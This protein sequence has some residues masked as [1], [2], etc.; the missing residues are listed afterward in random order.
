LL[1]LTVLIQQS[2]GAYNN[3]QGHKRKQVLVSR[4]T[5]A[6]PGATG[7]TSRTSAAPGKSGAP[8]ISGTSGSPKTISPTATIVPTTLTTKS[9]KFLYGSCNSRNYEDDEYQYSNKGNSQDSGDQYLDLFVRDT[10]PH[11]TDIDYNRNDND[12]RPRP[13]RT[14]RQAY[15]KVRFPVKR[16]RKPSRFP[17]SRFNRFV[18]YV[19]WLP[20]YADELTYQTIIFSPTGG[21]YILPPLVNFFGQRF[22]VAQ[23]IA[24][25]YASLVSGGAPPPPNINVAQFVGRAPPGGVVAGVVGAGAVG[26]APAFNPATSTFAGGVN[27][28]FGTF[29]E[30]K[31]R[32]PTLFDENDDPV[33]ETRPGESNRPRYPAELDDGGNNR[34]PYYGGGNN[35][36]PYGGY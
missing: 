17:L 34:R 11:E 26:P 7:A 18:N 3:Y 23:L 16:Y 28:D 31:P 30:R 10:E 12:E 2:F 5:V 15:T 29:R 8:G 4:I 13:P 36:R 21:M 27:S 20:I 9:N 6:L 33:P 1:S 22:A 32:Y 19:P 24:W 14:R 35:R 25:G